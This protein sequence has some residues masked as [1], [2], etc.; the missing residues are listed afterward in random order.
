MFGCLRRIGC[1]AVL[2]LL[3]PVAWVTR[4]MWWERVT[5]RALEPAVE[6]TPAVGAEAPEVV[7]KLGTLRGKGGP[8]F[9]SLGPSEV[10]ALL[11]S[12]LPASMVHDLE[13]SLDQQTMRF[14]ATMD[15]RPLATL[16]ALQPVSGMLTARQRVRVTGRPD[17]GPGGRGMLVVQELRIG[18]VVVP[19]PVLRPLVRQL[20][21]SDAAAAGSDGGAS[22][23]FSLPSAVA[24]MRVSRGRLILYKSTP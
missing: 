17:V 16:E 1:L 6:W 22:I 13:V 18:Q 4:P 24:D 8:A 9:V 14:R 12:G 23:S 15:L 10:G 11:R 5:G 3:V 7:K 20:G 21:G 19:T 2:L